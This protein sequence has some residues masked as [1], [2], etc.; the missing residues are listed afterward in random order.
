MEIGDPYLM[1][2]DQLFIVLVVD[3]NVWHGQVEEV[4][5]TGPELARRPG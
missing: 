3:G 2:A 4:E 1:I 5:V